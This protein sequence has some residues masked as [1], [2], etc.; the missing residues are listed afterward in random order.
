MKTTQTISFIVFGV[1]VAVGC[2]DDKAK[3]CA[4]GSERC[5]CFANA[6]CNDGLSCLSGICV[7]DHT[8]GGEGGGNG[9]G[10]NAGN[11]GGNEGGNAGNGGT[12]ATTRR[13]STGGSTSKDGTSTPVGGTTS[14]SN[15]GPNQIA[16]GDF[17]QGT[18]YW[19]VTMNGTEYNAASVVDGAYCVTASTYYDP[20]VGWPAAAEQALLLRYGYTYSLTF[21]IMTTTAANVSIKV[22]YFMAPYSVIY[23]AVSMSAVPTT[24]TESIHTFTV[25]GTGAMTPE[26]G[27][28]F[29]IKGFTSGLVCLD[30]VVLAQVL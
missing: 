11:G 21:R 22:G 12:T 28:A 16:N 30:D 10:G 18:T 9:V 4:T 13:G 2:G 24:W 23:Q 14:V 27:L 15:L 26:A 19:H 29:D 20:T 3:S 6:T 8:T 5:E 1:I 25:D 7:D 17:S